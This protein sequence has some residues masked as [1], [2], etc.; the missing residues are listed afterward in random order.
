MTG[1]LVP[2]HNTGAEEEVVA[3]LLAL[4]EHLPEVAD[5]LKPVHFWHHHLREM[6]ESIHRLSDSSSTI[7]PAS[8]MRDI[9]AASKSPACKAEDV[10]HISQE[11]P[12]VGNFVNKA[13]LVA[14]LARQREVIKALHHLAASGYSAEDPVKYASAVE[15]ELF[16]VLAEHEA[17]PFEYISESSERVL[18]KLDLRTKCEAPKDYIPSSLPLLNTRLFGWQPFPYVIAG[19]PGSGKTAFSLQEGYGIAERGKA[20]VFISLEMTRDQLVERLQCQLAGVDNR[21]MKNGH[22]TSRQWSALAEAH[23]RLSKLPVSIAAPSSITVA[24]VKGTA[25]RHLARLRRKHGS[26]LELGA[27]IVDYIQLMDG[28]GSTREERVASVSRGLRAVSKDLKVAVFEVCQM[29]RA[30]A[31]SSVPKQPTKTRRPQI[32][33]LRESGQI[34]QDAFGI[35]FVHDDEAEQFP[36][37]QMIL[38]KHRD[39][40]TGW[41]RAVF[42]GPTLT[43]S[44]LEQ[45][46]EHDL[47]EYDEMRGG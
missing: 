6:Y 26:D 17:E 14:G 23:E 15:S 19:R 11:V 35:L 16:R 3:T 32:S 22:L 30:V 27:I 33:D 29:N 2:P 7:D 46:E 20:V 12:V 40:S 41:T 10:Y 36:T 28:E 42:D 13:R 47:D 9:R 21:D 45:N 8:V 39:G 44:D 24:E 31:S 38:A 25:L 5:V 37:R 1:G 18:E 34:E 4:P 43:F